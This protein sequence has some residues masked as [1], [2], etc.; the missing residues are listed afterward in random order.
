MGT[1]ITLGLGLI[2]GFLVGY[3]FAKDRTTGDPEGSNE[4]TVPQLRAYNQDPYNK[5]ELEKVKNL[6]NNSKK[7]K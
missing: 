4:S 1:I 7:Q 2:I 6:F 5:A 3:I